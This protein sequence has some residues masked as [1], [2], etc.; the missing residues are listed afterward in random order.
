M[1]SQDLGNRAAALKWRR[2]Q[3]LGKPSSTGRKDSASREQSPLMVKGDFTEAFTKL[4]H[5]I[6]HPDG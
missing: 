3:G 1:T 6:A 2:D 4:G 5:L